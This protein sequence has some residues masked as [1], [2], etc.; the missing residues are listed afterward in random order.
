[1]L[2]K[3]HKQ[4]KIILLKI[5]SVQTNA[6]LAT[7]CKR[8]RVLKLFSLACDDRRGMRH[9]IYVHATCFPLTIG[10]DVEMQMK[11]EHKV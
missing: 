3:Q 6:Q 7:M 2:H 8:E 5:Y 9:L 10:G 1:M 4:N 11:K